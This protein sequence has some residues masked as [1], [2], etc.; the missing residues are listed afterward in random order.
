[1]RGPATSECSE[2]MFEERYR[3]GFLDEADYPRFEAPAFVG[4]CVVALA[5]DHEVSAKTGSILQTNEIAEAY[6]LER[7]DGSH[8]SKTGSPI[9]R[10]VS[11][12]VL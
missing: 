3:K 1:M 8:V 9:S 4:Q 10:Q 6:G 7:L 12:S 2:K 5:G 11:I